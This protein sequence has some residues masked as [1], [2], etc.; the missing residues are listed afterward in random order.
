MFKMFKSD[1]ADKQFSLETAIK[2]ID[3]MSSELKKLNVKSQLLLCDLTLNFSHPVKTTVSREVEEKKT[4][5]EELHNSIKFHAD[6][7]INNSSL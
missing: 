6:V 4:D 1:V 3:K 5:F 7:S 2:N